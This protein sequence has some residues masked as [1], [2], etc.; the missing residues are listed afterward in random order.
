MK[1]LVAACAAALLSGCAGGLHSSAPAVQAY[2]LRAAAP[3]PPAGVV[4][5]GSLRIS[6]PT[7]A[8]GLDS[9]HISILQPDQRLGFYAAS[10]WASALPDVI[11]SLAVQTFRASGSFRSVEDSHAAFPTEYLLQITVR[12]FE[13]DYQEQSGAPVIHVTFD[14]MLGR[15][16]TRELVAMFVAE[17]SENATANRLASVVAAFEHAA[18]A[19]LASAAEQSAAAIKTSTT[20]APP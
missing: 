14:C 10:R 13:A 19:A 8:P 18:D 20:R 1:H 12:R 16:S 11:E 7:A 4:P 5:L 6:R 9:D 17:S 3:A 15:Q 2:V